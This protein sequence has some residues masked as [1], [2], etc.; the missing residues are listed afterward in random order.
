MVRGYAI[1]PGGEFAR[2]HDHPWDV[3]AACALVAIPADPEPACANTE[4]TFRPVINGRRLT[5][6][7][8]IDAEISV[9]RC[10]DQCSAKVQ[11]H[12]GIGRRHAT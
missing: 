7:S 10:I 12:A 1:P 9:D 3:R 4:A 8:P 6:A 2:M 5:S 11:W